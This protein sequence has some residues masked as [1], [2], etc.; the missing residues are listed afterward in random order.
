MLLVHTRIAFLAVKILLILI[1]QKVKV[2]HSF[3]AVRAV[4]ELTVSWATADERQDPVLCFCCS[5][6]YKGYPFTAGFR[7]SFSVDDLSWA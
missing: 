4:G 6:P 3:V 1:I 2:S 7:E 5:L